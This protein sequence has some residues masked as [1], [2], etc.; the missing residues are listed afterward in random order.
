[1]IRRQRTEAVALDFQR[2]VEPRAK[3]LQGDCRCQF[4]DLFRTE[5]SLDLCVHGIGNVGWRMRHSFSI[6]QYGLFRAIEM[7]TYLEG[8]Q[9]RQLLVGDPSVSAHGR[10]DIHSK[11][12]PHHLRRTDR[13]HG[14]EATFDDVRS[15]D[16]LAQLC[17]GEQHLRPMSQHEIWRNHPPEQVETFLKYRL[18]AR[19]RVFRVDSFDAHAMVSMVT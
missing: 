11:G 12:T 3:I 5:Q 2:A 15:A 6:A 16:G 9:I 1:M 14:L 10:V 13:D 4:D 7:W 8:G 18:H 17:R 19:G